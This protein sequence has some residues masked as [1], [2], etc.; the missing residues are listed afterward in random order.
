MQRGEMER[1][2]HEGGEVHRR[3]LGPPKF[4]PDIDG[5]GCAVRSQGDPA[6]LLRDRFR[7]IDEARVAF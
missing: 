3:C 5:E 4:L 6:T 1:E 2:G 7:A